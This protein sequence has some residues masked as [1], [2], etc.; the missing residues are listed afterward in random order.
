MVIN[1]ITT[2]YLHYIWQ[3]YFF[4]SYFL[5]NHLLHFFELYFEYEL[6]LR[7]C[8]VIEMND[9]TPEITSVKTKQEK[10]IFIVKFN[11]Y[12]RFL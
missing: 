5:S 4:P 11:S 8:C 2:K 7:L 6:D 12:K 10:L 9:R 3:D 1:E